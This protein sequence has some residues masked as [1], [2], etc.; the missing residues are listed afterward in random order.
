MKTRTKTASTAAALVAAFLAVPLG[1]HTFAPEAHAQTRIVDGDT[2]EL[3]GIKHRLHGIDAPEAGQTCKRPNGQTWPCGRDAITAL[4]RLARG[5]HVECFGQSQDGYGR[6]ISVCTADGLDLNFALVRNGFAWAFTKYSTDYADAQNAA[7][8]E[9]LGIWQADTQTPWDYRAAKWQEGQT[10]APNGCP[11]KGNISSG[12]KIYHAPWSPWYGRTK[13][14]EAKGE[15][16]FCG[17][18]EALAAGWRAP[19]WGRG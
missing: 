9:R 8:I 3:D 18:D 6:T 12:G 5:S 14:N 10:Q 16:W 1:L 11:I 17:E 2:I 4:E 15:R 7:Q 19:F 13:I